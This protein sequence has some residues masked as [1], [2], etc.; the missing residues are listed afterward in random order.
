M[1]IQVGTR[2]ICRS[3]GFVTTDE[4]AANAHT[5]QTGH[6]FRTEGIF[7]PKVIHHSAITHQECSCGARR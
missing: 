3:C 4:G 5:R 6:G 1:Q 7:E 2:Y